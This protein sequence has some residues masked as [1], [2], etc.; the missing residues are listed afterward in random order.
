MDRIFVSLDVSFPNNMLGYDWPVALRSMLV[1][2]MNSI[3]FPSILSMMLR[4][5]I[6]DALVSCGSL[7]EDMDSE[8][9]FPA[10]TRPNPHEVSLQ[11]C[12]QFPN[13]MLTY[14]WPIE[15]RPVTPSFSLTQNF[16]NMYSLNY[17]K[18]MIPS[19]FPPICKRSYTNIHFFCYFQSKKAQKMSRLQA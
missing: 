15:V 5:P 1:L 17:V 9:T 7:K 8:S 12:V 6:V 13:N 18:Y 2:E 11:D 19:I 3:N 10:G 14:D 4:D 16:F